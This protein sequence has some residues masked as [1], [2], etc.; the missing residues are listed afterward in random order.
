M[1]R[2]GTPWTP[3]ITPLVDVFAFADFYVAQRATAGQSIQD[4]FTTYVASV[5]PQPDQDIW[6]EHREFSAASP[7]GFLSARL[8][9]RL[10]CGHWATPVHPMSS[11]WD[12][13]YEEHE[14]PTCHTWQQY[15]QRVRDHLVKG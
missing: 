3:G 10:A 14:C 9:A 4:A 8:S 1:V 15:D 11:D 12:F 13:P 7:T 6:Q 5:T 2:L